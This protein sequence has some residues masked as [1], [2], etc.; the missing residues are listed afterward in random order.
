MKRTILVSIVVICLIVAVF[1]WAG[2][3]SYSSTSAVRNLRAELE[4]IYGTEY[5]GK[6]Q[7][8]EQKIWCLQ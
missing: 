5:T 7:K 6:M 2:V 1:C 8:T 3:G 4:T